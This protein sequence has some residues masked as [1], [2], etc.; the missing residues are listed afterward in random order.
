MNDKLLIDIT[1][2]TL[3]LNIIAVHGNEALQSI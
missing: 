3:F 2:V 1:A